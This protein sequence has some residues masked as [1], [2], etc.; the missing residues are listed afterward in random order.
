MPKGVN[1]TLTKVFDF[2]IKFVIFL[3]LV[4]AL[5]YVLGLWDTLLNTV[6]NY[7]KALLIFVLVPTFYSFVKNY[8]KYKVK[9]AK[10][11]QNQNL[12]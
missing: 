1:Y 2:I 11:I 9:I 7:G 8:I 3:L 10:K 4:F 6:N 12:I 5:L